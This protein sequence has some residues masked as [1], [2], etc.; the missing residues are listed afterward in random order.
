[1]AYSYINISKPCCKWRSDASIHSFCNVYVWQLNVYFACASVYPGKRVGDESIPPFHERIPFAAERIPRVRERIPRKARGGREYT[2]VFWKVYLSQLNVYL[3][4]AS[5][6]P[7]KRRGNE[8]I[9]PFDESIPF[10]KKAYTFLYERYTPQ[11]ERILLALLAEWGRVRVTGFRSA[12]RPVW[13]GGRN[14][15]WPRTLTRV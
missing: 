8:S 9:P 14:S 13:G 2:S 4:C 15:G 11:T 3:A 10:S 12:G 5:V 7:G 6:Y 1:M